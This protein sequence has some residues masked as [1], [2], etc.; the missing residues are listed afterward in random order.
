M[1]TYIKTQETGIRTGKENEKFRFGS[2]DTYK[3]E[4]YYEIKMSI[5]FVYSEL[6]L[7]SEYGVLPL[8]VA[9][10]RC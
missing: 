6:L 4:V 10:K 8:C 5:R 2:S 1:D 7:I 3:S 9:N